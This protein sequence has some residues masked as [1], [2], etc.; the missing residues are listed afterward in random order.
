VVIVPGERRAS[1]HRARATQIR[2]PYTRSSCI[3]VQVLFH[4]LGGLSCHGDFRQPA[5]PGMSPARAIA[6]S[7]WRE[8]PE[9]SPGTSARWFIEWLLM[10]TYE[11]VVR[12]SSEMR[13]L[14]PMRFATTGV[15]DDRFRFRN[16]AQKQTPAPR[17]RACLFVT[18][19]NSPVSPVVWRQF[20]EVRSPSITLIRLRQSLDGVSL[21]CN[22]SCNVNIRL[23]IRGAPT[24]KLFISYIY[25]CAKSAYSRWSRIS[26]LRP[27][28]GVWCGE[29]FIVISRFALRAQGNRNSGCKEQPSGHPF[30]GPGVSVDRIYEYHIFCF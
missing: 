3:L 28:N 5:L 11:P 20:T 24:K 17:G 13:V 18:A 21:T 2:G 22:A 26:Y 27:P 19:S 12:C 10:T 15:E 29:T 16:G 1:R 8:S 6:R 30:D 23:P 25:L 14:S 4:V 9:Y 7:P